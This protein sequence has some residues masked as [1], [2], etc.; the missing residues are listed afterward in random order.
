MVW[1]RSEYAE[2][3][4]VLLA[5][6]SALLPWN[7]SFSQLGGVGD[8]LFV[9]FPL[10]QVRYT[11]GVPLARGTLVLDPIS[12]ARFQQGTTVATAY[13]VW[14]VGA[15]LVAAALVL[16]FALYFEDERVADAD[17][18]PVRAMGALLGGAAVVL[19]VATVLVWT[20]GVPAIHV[21]L[22]LVV[23]YVFGGVLLTVERT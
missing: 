13:W 16:S 18:D 11:Y 21:P 3:L 7:V 8:L 9:R 6:L 1:V 10:V 22:G 19:T 12:A 15:A 2:E 23:L 14:A 5:W 4:A 17:F 20:R